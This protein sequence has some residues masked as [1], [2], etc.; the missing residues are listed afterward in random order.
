MSFFQKRSVAILCCIVMIAAALCIGQYKTQ[1]ASVSMQEVP[2]T[3]WTEM[4]HNSDV[5]RNT[6]FH[7]F[8][9]SLRI[10][11]GVAV[12][13]LLIG[14]LVLLSVISA[15]TRLGRKLFSGAV[16]RKFHEVHAEPQKRKENVSSKYRQ[17]GGTSDKR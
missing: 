11:I 1:R 2:P 12:F 8:G 17:F 3:E 5:D 10:V 13:V 7:G 16:E 9:T 14:T 15:I 6:I 4:F